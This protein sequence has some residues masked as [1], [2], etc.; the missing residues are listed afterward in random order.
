MLKFIGGLIVA[1]FVLV[2]L[3]GV[4]IM[5]FVGW[6]YETGRGEHTGY[7]TAVERHGLIF[8]TNTVYLK[9]DTQSSQEDAYCVIDDEVY[10]Q[11]QKLST[12]KTHVNA[13][14]F[15]WA[16]AGVTNCNGEGDII[17]KVEPIT[18]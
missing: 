6:H 18:K 10:A 11:L 8:K 1:F 2:G 16:V 15:S 13:Y 17:Y 9:T 3:Y 7:I 4:F 5:P 14:F 12:E